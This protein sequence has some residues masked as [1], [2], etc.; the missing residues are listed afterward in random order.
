MN[1]VTSWKISTKMKWI[2]WQ[3]GKSLLKWS[4]KMRRES[5]WP[6]KSCLSKYDPSRH[7]RLLCP[8]SSL[9]SQQWPPLVSLLRLR[10]LPYGVS[11]DEPLELRRRSH[12]P[13]SGGR[14]W[15]GGSGRAKAA[16]SVQAYTLI[17]PYFS[18][19]PERLG[20]NEGAK[21]MLCP[22]MEKHSTMR[23]GIPPWYYHL[24]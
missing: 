18:A 20:K 1:W 3:N 2:E 11:E 12:R 16:A 7:S 19:V 13:R 24:G 23:S 14:W 8:S 6:V 21:K 15:R 5:G 4:G 9:R 10:L 22:R 17:A